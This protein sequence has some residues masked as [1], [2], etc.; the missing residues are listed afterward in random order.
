MSQSH[1]WHPDPAS[2]APRAIRSGPRGGHSVATEKLSEKQI[3]KEKAQQELW[4]RRVLRNSPS[5]Q[6]PFLWGPPG[7]SQASLTP[8]WETRSL[9]DQG[10]SAPHRE[11]GATPPHPWHSGAVSRAGKAQ[12]GAVFASVGLRLSLRVCPP[13][14]SVLPPVGRQP[15]HPPPKLAVYDL[16]GIYSLPCQ[17]RANQ[18]NYLPWEW[19]WEK[20]VEGKKEERTEVE[21]EMRIRVRCERAAIIIKILHVL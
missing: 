20:D 12:R 11:E 17:H 1:S 3:K 10:P 19:A 2:W 21:P 5:S 4:C 6:G 9:W 15:L 7:A 18:A 13:E 14:L 16:P 8:P